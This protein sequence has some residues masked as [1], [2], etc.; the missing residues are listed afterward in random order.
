L[1][2]AECILCD[3]PAVHWND[4]GDRLTGIVAHAR[5][6][7]CKQMSVSTPGSNLGRH[8]FGVAALAIGL[9]TLAWHDY[10]DWPQL[11]YLVYAAS[12]AQ[13]FGGAAIQF[14]QAAKTGAVILGAGCLIFV[15]LCLPEMVTAPQIYNSWG[16]FFEQLSLL[17]GAALVYAP[18]SSKWSRETLNRVGR[19]LLGLCTASFTLEQASYLG[20]TADLVPKWIPPSPMFWAVATTVFFALAALALLTNRMAL[21]AARLLTLMLVS[22]G[23]LVWIPLLLSDTHNH[24]HWSEFAETFAIAG[25]AWILADLLGEYRLNDQRPR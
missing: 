20:P 3:P 25:T 21:L 16:N 24:M 18:L 2:K 1:Y 19:I 15:L 13:M 6:Q 11:R 4:A 10:N 22:F 14:R 17:T 5:E 9:I 23:L 12:A 8:L 7:D